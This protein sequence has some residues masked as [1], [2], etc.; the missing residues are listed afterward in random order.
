[1]IW[2]EGF[3][4]GNG[5]IITTTNELHVRSLWTGFTESI[6]QSFSNLRIPLSYPGTLTDLLM[7]IV[8]IQM[9][10]MVWKPSRN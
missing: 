2:K 6:S 4:R 8:L 1:M 9:E 10:Q 5:R 3:I 7:Q